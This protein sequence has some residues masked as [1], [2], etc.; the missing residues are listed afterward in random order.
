[1]EQSKGAAPLRRRAALWTAGSLAAAALFGMFAVYSYNTNRRQPQQDAQQI[2]SGVPIPEEGTP[3]EPDYQ[4]L[5]R[6]EN[7]R[8]AVYRTGESEP[9]MVFD[10][11][12]RALPE[13]DQRQL[14]EGIP[15]EDYPTLV[16]RIEDYIKIG[17]AHV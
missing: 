7:G 15:V 5:L 6:E 17:R 8:L 14:A 4:Y 3:Q 9:Q 11:P 2:V 10:V 1:M 12:V 16:R 13:F